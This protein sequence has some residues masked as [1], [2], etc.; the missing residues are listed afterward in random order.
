MR[1][2]L[3]SLLV[4]LVAALWIWMATSALEEAR[5]ERDAALAQVEDAQLVRDVLRAHRMRLEGLNNQLR[6]RMEA[7]NALEGGDVPASDFLRL[8]A[9]E[10]WE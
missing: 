3:L 6:T 2:V 5:E 10:L 7:I 9:R 8:G 4:I 1:L